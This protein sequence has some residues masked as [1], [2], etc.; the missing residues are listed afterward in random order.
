[1]RSYLLQAEV[2]LTS[3][4]KDSDGKMRDKEATDLAEELRTNT[5]TKQLWLSGARFRAVCAR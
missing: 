1:M 2:I 4:S 3:F 5:H